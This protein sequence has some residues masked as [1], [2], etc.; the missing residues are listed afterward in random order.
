MP[1]KPPSRGNTTVEVHTPPSRRANESLP[2]A[3]PTRFSSPVIHHRERLGG[4]GRTQAD[5]DLD[6]IAPAPQV[7]I[8]EIPYTTQNMP[9]TRP[10]LEE[11]RIAS[12]VQLPQPDAQG[13]RWFK[14]RQFVDML[15]GSIFLVGLDSES[16]LYRA[17]LSS[18]RVPSGPLLLQDPDSRLWYPMVDLESMTFSLS[19]R[20]LEDFRT[21]LDFSNQVPDSDGLHRF[22]GKLYLVI[23]NQAYQAMH[24]VEASSPNLQVM[25]IVRPQDAVARDEHNRYVATRPGRSEAVFYDERIGWSGLV[26]GGAGGMFPGRGNTSGNPSGAQLNAALGRFL[27]T[28]LGRLRKLYPALDEP[29][30]RAAMDSLGKDVEGGLKRLEAELATLK[31]DLVAWIQQT[32]EASQ[33]HKH[34][35]VRVNDHILRCWRRE[36]GTILWLPEG[37]GGALPPLKV[38]FGHIE[39]L[40]IKGIAWPGTGDDFLTHFPR[41]TRL[42]IVESG[43]TAVPDS[44]RAMPELT[45]LDLHSNRIVLDQKGA[46]ALG[47]MVR[48]KQ[49]DLSGNPLG[50]TPDF[51]NMSEL[52]NLNLSHTGIDQWPAGLRT[53]TEMD[54]IDLR[55]NR[56]RE[57]PPE[58]LD[59]SG[60]QGLTQVR[61]NAVTL[62]D[63]NQFS[64]GYWQHFDR[65]W[66]LASNRYPIN[67]IYTVKDAFILPS[68]LV[69]RL[70]NIHPHKSIHEAREFLSGLGP[71]TEATITRLERE[72]QTLESQLNAWSFSGGG[73]RQRYVRANQMQL[74]PDRL[75]DR[76]RAK[77]RILACWRRETP[78]KYAA[79]GTPIGLELKLNGLRLDSVPDLNDV[80]FSH[81]GSLKLSG[82]NLSVSPDGFLAR[83]Q[84]V[85]WLDM[86]NNQLRELPA[87]IGQMHAMTRLS[88]QNNRITL[89]PETAR[90]LSERVTLRALMLNDNPL[91]ITPDFSAITDMRSLNLGNTSIDT[92]PPGLSAQPALEDI[93]LYDNRITTIPDAIID[94]PDALLLQQLRVNS[95]TDVS[96]NP[97]SE[98]SLERIQ[99]FRD[100][101]A[102]QRLVSGDLS[103]LLSITR[104]QPSLNTQAFL[105]NTLLRNALPSAH[106]PSDGLLRWTQGMPAQQVALKR[107][108]WQRLISQQGA[109]AFF[110]VLQRLNAGPVA[111]PDLQR[112]VWNVLDSISENSAESDQLRRDLFDRAGE[113]ACC[114]RAAFSFGN[115]EVLTM[116]YSAR[117]QAGDHALGPQLVHLS[118]R[119]LRLQE[120]DRLAAEDIQRSEAIVRDPQVSE[121]EKR[122]HVLRLQ[123]EVEIRL[124]YRFGLKDSLELPGQPE[125]VSFIG[126]GRVTREMLSGVYKA[127]IDLDNSPAERQALLS[128]EF[129]KDYLTSKYRQQFEEQREPYQARLAELHESLEAKQLTMEQYQ[130]KSDDLQGQLA[131]D[132]ATLMQTLTRQELDQPAAPDDSHVS[133][134]QP[135]KA[136]TPTTESSIQG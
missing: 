131:I 68:P 25:R 106:S 32:A 104:A 8:S 66:E 21:S 33:A 37:G 55:S 100:R 84:H 52:R 112:R 77:T 64:E 128:R 108:Q 113:P 122:P 85:R 89:T 38:S 9:A 20:R 29:G 14:G 78:Q 34:W 22:E 27:Q 76:Y 80:D 1:V 83:F 65:F 129:W 13:F 136:M 4:S 39:V 31:E 48:L 74:D 5:I 16:G 51:S 18:E 105:E 72:F 58:L 115:L 132:E 17:R 59:P 111:H 54:Q 11:Y 63:G 69:K 88:L 26:V 79:D 91:G 101:V 99:R 120:V 102:A 7:N 57:V 24:D 60:E 30:L 114:D 43:L 46:Q 98:V 103:R 126:M 28:H 23:D 93:L 15:D 67:E 109:Q 50:M 10:S 82:M 56:L 110:T 47:S 118:R 44:I 133:G 107:E 71:D 97:L 42:S 3:D 75:G 70:Q 124:A 45:M 127:V 119:L 125:N 116:V 123:E 135:N 96:G 2:G 130:A 19:S 6:A 121:E 12:D 49:L 134:S 35:A 53:Q 36:S 95:V 87:A 117:K 92:W 81:V 86:S 94:P 62:L 41:L 73:S 61:I 40:K 90:I